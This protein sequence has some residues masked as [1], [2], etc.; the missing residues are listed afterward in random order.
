MPRGGERKGTQGKAYVNR[1]DLAV[2]YAPGGNPATGGIEPPRSIMP[3]RIGADQVP[4]LGDP[5][6]NPGQPITTGVDAGLGAGR[7]ALGPIPP[8][9]TDPI[10]QMLQAMLLLGPNPDV[11]RLLNRLDYQGR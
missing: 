9:P 1:T 11:Q 5:N 4:N 10:K 3:P 8:S 7:S 2:D 6:P